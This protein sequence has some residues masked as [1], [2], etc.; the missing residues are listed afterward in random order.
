[1]ICGSFMPRR[2]LKLKAKFESTLSKFGVK[3]LVQALSTQVS[4]VQHASPTRSDPLYHKKLRGQIA[5]KP[6]FD[7]LIDVRGY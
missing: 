3:L 6:R 4:L 7:K 1:M 2:K 5:P